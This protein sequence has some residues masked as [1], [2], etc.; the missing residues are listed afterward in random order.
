MARADAQGDDPLD[1]VELGL[2]SDDHEARDLGWPCVGAHRAVLAR[3]VA[4]GM[5]DGHRFAVVPRGATT[6]TA[7][8]ADL[9]A[10][11]RR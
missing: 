4:R 11:K 1:V 2:A 10:A 9:H 3:I 8:A 6:G 7:G 5:A